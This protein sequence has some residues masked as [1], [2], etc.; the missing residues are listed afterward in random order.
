[1]P[2]IPRNLPPDNEPGHHPEVEQDKPTGPPPGPGPVRFPLA[3][4]PTFRLVDRVLGITEDRAYVELDRDELRIRFGPW[5][6]DVPRRTVAGAEV[7]GPYWLPKVLGP[8]HLSL[9]D[10]GITFATN[11]R[12]GVCIRLTEPVKALEPLGLLR[13]PSITVTVED[14]KALADAL[15]A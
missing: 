5:S 6:A 2:E 11:R 4:D 15:A 1:V 9:A 7:T 8:P 10:R 13:H 12:K 3:F 14:P